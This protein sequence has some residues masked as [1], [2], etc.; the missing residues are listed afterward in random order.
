MRERV[1]ISV[2]VASYNSKGTIE[3]C[4]RSLE[5]QSH[6][7]EVE[8]IVV[9]SST[10]G[11]AEFVE[12]KFPKVRLFNFRERKY[13]G[14][15]RNIGISEAKG[16]IVAF[17]DADCIADR[18]W[19]EEIL[20]AHQSPHMA[21][22][23]AISNGTPDRCV[24]WAAF[25][26]EFSQWMPNRHRR[27]MTDIAGANMSYKREVFAEFGRFI[28]ATYCSDTDFHWRLGQ[29]GHRL[30]FVP[31][32]VVYHRYLEDW[33]RYLN[34]EYEHGQ[35]FARV[36]VKSRRFSKYKRLAYVLCSPMIALKILLKI[37][38]IH[39]RNRIYMKYFLKALPMS[40]TGIIFWSMG[41]CIG[42]AKGQRV[43][44]D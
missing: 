12:E 31:S 35:S 32:I 26:C 17:I 29:S 11:T 20:S 19:L 42:Y 23:G 6:Y 9:D 3:G 34:H 38:L 25:F 22:G 28:E 40:A 16:D 5:D 14:D 4:L 43:G 41:E 1:R 13:C 44:G 7:G 10:D 36:R 18:N 39:F 24:A 27:Y 30:L 15:A 37:G 21:I 8:I 33:K 2:I